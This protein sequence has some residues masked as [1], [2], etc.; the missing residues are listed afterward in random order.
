MPPLPAK[1]PFLPLPSSLD[2]PQN[3]HNKDSNWKSKKMTIRF[4]KL[5]VISA[6]VALVRLCLS[7]ANQA[8]LVLRG[9]MH[10]ENVEGEPYQSQ[11]DLKMSSKK[12][13][14]SRGKGKGMG[15]SSSK[16]SKSGKGKGKGK[17]K[18]WAYDRHYR[19]PPTRP[20]ILDLG[21]LYQLRRTTPVPTWTPPDEE[22]LVVPQPTLPP[23]LAPVISTEAPQQQQLMTTVSPTVSPTFP[24]TAPPSR[25]TSPPPTWDDTPQP[26]AGTTTT[27]QQRTNNLFTRADPRQVKLDCQLSEGGLFGMPSDAS[28]V[29]QV[30]FL[31]QIYVRA[32]TT[33]AVLRSQVAPLLDAGV[34]ELLLP[35]F[36]DCD[37]N[38][39]RRR[40]L[41]STG[42][43]IDGI[44]S[45]PEDEIFYFGCK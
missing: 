35:A 6:L 27:L 45:R 7:E 38:R 21:D 23:T 13:L 1:N 43:T 19:Q 26:T 9:G 5:L 34:T 3:N 29:Y 8:P 37:N 28:S 41:Q 16:S 33:E 25:D 44:S 36:F 14:F 32:G 4:R 2:S 30:E 12:N 18:G 39:R 17:G 24:K 11:R 40:F 22:S 31:Y 42:G 10:H 15:K 20:P